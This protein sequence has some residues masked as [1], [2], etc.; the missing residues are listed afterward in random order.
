MQDVS[1][2]NTSP[3][4]Q[5]DERKKFTGPKSFRGFRETGPRYSQRDNKAGN[6]HIDIPDTNIYKSLT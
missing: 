1:G 5:T 3:F 6:K 4:L 2:I